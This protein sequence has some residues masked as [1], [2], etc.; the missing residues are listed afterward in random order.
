MTSEYEK[1]MS[2][3]IE[4]AKLSLREGNNGFGALIVKGKKIIA[5]A[6]DTEETDRDPTAHA[7]MNVIK[8]AS[9]LLEKNLEDCLLMTTHE[10]CPMCAAAIVWTKIKNIAYG[11][12][13]ED[14]IKQ[15]R[16]R[17]DMSCQELFARANIHVHVEKGILRDKCALLYNKEIRQEIIKLRNATD[18][19]LR[20]YDRE[21]T[22][23]RL[24]WFRMGIGLLLSS[25]S[26]KKDAG[27]Q[28]LLKRFNITEDQAPIIQRDHNSI[29]FHSQNF[30]PTLEA[31]IILEMDTRRVCKLYNEHS[32]NMLIQQFD[33]RLRFRRNYEKLRPFAPYCEEMICFTE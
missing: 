5:E 30:C 8:M 3:A 28:L 15:G 14:A 2:V 32:T 19:Q 13:I 4:Q 6:H 17:I 26:D 10:P 11:Y 27:Y 20:E 33:P 22:Q 7:E 29:V 25:L 18:E 12:S 9:K 16:N 1:Y 24:A 31:C 23:K 21:S